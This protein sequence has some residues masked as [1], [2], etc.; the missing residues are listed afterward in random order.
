MIKRAWAYDALKQRDKAEADFAAAVRIDPDNWEAHSGLGYV[1]AVQK[2]MPEAQQEAELAL[3]H[4][5]DNYL[6]MHNVA[7]IHSVLSVNDGR[8]RRWHEDVA[9]A[10]LQRAVKLWKQAGTG[11]NEIAL[12]KAEADTTFLCLKG[13]R[14]FQDLIHEK[15]Q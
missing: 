13:R 1:R 2:L 10:M 3:L 14:D 8:Q 7:C 11:P 9:M 5:G 15:D 6:V 12:I 4:G